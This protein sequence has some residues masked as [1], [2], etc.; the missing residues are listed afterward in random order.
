M[1]PVMDTMFYFS[2]SVNVP[3]NIAS[4][5]SILWD[6]S[7]VCLMDWGVSYI[8]FMRTMVL[9]NQNFYLKFFI[10]L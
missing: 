3:Q 9:I 10:R 4:L 6:S 8:P 5:Q 2:V 7:A 1:A